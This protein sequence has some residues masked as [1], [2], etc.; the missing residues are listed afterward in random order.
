MVARRLRQTG[1]SGGLLRG[2][3]SLAAA[4]KATIWRV[5]HFFAGE[6]KDLE[7]QGLFLRWCPRETVGSYILRGLH[8]DYILRDTQ[9]DTSFLL[10]STG[11]K[12]KSGFSSSLSQSK[13]YSTDMYPIC[14]LAGS[15]ALPSSAK[16]LK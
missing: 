11:Y 15:F 16:R 4:H 14:E 7:F 9:R 5:A 3:F 6:K 13:P 12:R 8:P 1:L 2:G 10:L